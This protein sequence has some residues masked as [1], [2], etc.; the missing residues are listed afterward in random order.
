MA[1]PIAMDTPESVEEAG[2]LLGAAITKCN[3][4]S[5]PSIKPPKG[6]HSSFAIMSPVPSS[7]LFTRLFQLRAL[8]RDC[9]NKEPLVA[10]PSLLAV[11]MKLLGV[12]SSLAPQFANDGRVN[13][14]P[15]WSTPLR[16]L[17]VD[18]VVLCHV[19]GDSLTGKARIDFLK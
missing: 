19:L 5:I 13:T 15:L 8:L 9:D 4:T 11:L 1:S 16:K 10:A 3:V 7:E 12:S 18:C 14:P 2:A 17:W 6:M